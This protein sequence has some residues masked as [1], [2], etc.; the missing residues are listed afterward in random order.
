MRCT[1]CG[2]T[3][4]AEYLYGLPKFDDN[5]Q[6]ELDEKK[7]VLGGC[8]VSD[9]DPKY[10]CNNC[11]ADF[12]YSPLREIDNGI[13][14]YMKD[15]YCIEFSVVYPDSPKQT[16]IWKKDNDKYY[17][18]VSKGREEFIKKL[19]EKEYKKNLS[20]FFEKAYLLEMDSMV[21][22]DLS[23]YCIN[24]SIKIKCTGAK[25]IT[26]LGDNVRSTY[27]RKAKSRYD[28][29]SIKSFTKADYFDEHIVKI[30][31]VDIDETK[32][33]LN[34]RKTFWKENDCLDRCSIF[35]EHYKEPLLAA[36]GNDEESIRDFI[37]TCE[38]EELM[39]MSEVFEDIYGMFTNEDMWN[40]LEE[41]E[42]KLKMYGGQ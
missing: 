32:K 9:F 39:Y 21:K 37:R 11:N 17:V 35:D 4:T 13:V 36:L 7:I 20:V 15:T 8:M 25:D 22:D 23:E 3:N 18:V 30:Q 42:N 33:L 34:D 28:Y 26:I 41:M 5:L 31:K 24:W 27:Y 10:K 6:K 16:V 2:S 14:D 1:K 40:F 19:T 12:G 29:Y 38:G